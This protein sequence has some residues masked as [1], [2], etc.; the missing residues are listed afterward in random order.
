MPVLPS[1]IAMS[2]IRG[3]NR[4][5]SYIPLPLPIPPSRVQ[6]FI[7]SIP[8]VPI[9]VNNRLFLFLTGMEGGYPGGWAVSVFPLGIAYQDN[10]PGGNGTILFLIDQNRQ[11]TVCIV[12][13]GLHSYTFTTKTDKTSLFNYS[14][15]YCYVNS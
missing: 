15:N 5:L 11:K 9:A 4:Y 12:Q 8:T 7:S 6:Q 13:N 3:S 10:R 2:S 1:G 14:L